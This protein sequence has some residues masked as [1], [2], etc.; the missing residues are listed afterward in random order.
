MSEQ[1]TTDPETEKRLRESYIKHATLA[2]LHRWWQ[3]H[4]N[5]E[6]GI[7]NHLDLLSEDAIVRSANSEVIGLDAYREMALKKQSSCRT[8]HFLKSHT[9]DISIDGSI[10]LTADIIQFNIG[11]LPENG[12][13]KSTVHFE[14]TLQQTD[15]V[16]PLFTNILISQTGSGQVEIFQNAYLE[17]RIRSLV[18]QFTALV[19]DPSRNPEPFR[20]VLADEFSLNYLETPMTDF[21]MVKTWVAS[22]LS[23]VVA[24]NHQIHDVS[25]E[26]ADTGDYLVTIKM[27]SRALFPDGSGVTSKNT[28]TWTLADSISDRFARIKKIT[29]D[30]DEVR[31]F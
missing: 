24:S 31:R 19:E 25:F 22:A 28:Q 2:Q 8:A 26:V 12:V 11:T 6:S 18:H 17:N 14:A 21:E 29:I 20:E 9:I 7:S 15:T 10:H 3:Y 1:R 4:E 23:S 27:D 13:S 16:L 5:A 30:R